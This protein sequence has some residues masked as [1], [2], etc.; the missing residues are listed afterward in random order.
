M[1]VEPIKHEFVVRC[2]V[3]RAF[4]VYVNHIGQWWDPAYAADTANCVT[5][6]IEPKLGGRVYETHRDGG[7]V[8]WGTVTAWEP[9]HRLGYTSILGHGSR[10]PSAIAV[11]FAAEGHNCQ[12]TFAHGGWT[13]SNKTD[14]ARFTHWQAILNRYIGCAEGR[15]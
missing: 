2:P 13:E 3:P 7:T 1:P 15:R 9:Q 10:G 6:T 4:D 5:V 14:R 11:G 12:V 8:Q